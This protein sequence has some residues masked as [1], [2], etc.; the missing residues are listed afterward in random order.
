MTGLRTSVGGVAIEAELW[1]CS[2][3]SSFVIASSRE[4]YP[5]Q[6]KFPT[7]EPAGD[8]AIYG[9]SVSTLDY[10]PPTIRSWLKAKVF[11]LFW[12]RN[13]DEKECFKTAPRIMDICRKTW[14]YFSR[15]DNPL[16]FAKLF[17]L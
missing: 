17:F 5:P 15:K 8:V 11:Y 13:D 10:Q 6:R 1:H 3:T 4:N 2:E 9:M 7:Q 14:G 12:A 16:K